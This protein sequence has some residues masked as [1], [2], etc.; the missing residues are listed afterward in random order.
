MTNVFV[1][2]A[3]VYAVVSAV[4]AGVIMLWPLG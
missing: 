1:T 3:V 2:T 4:A